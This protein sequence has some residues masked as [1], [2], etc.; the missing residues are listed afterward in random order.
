M[1]QVQHVGLPHEQMIEDHASRLAND[2]VTNQPKVFQF[3]GPQTSGKSALLRA[4]KT[5]L[6]EL[7]QKP[8]LVDPPEHALDAGLIALL[9]VG[10]ALRR[11]DLI[12]GQLDFLT[13]GEKTWSD[14]LMEVGQWLKRA[15]SESIVLLLDEP[16]AWLSRS[17]DDFHFG[18]CAAD[19][20]KLLTSQDSI[21]LVIA[22]TP[23]GHMSR[24]VEV[25]PV[26]LRGN[27]T[28]WLE[29]RGEWGK[30]VNHACELAESRFDLHKL[31]PL[32]LRI[33]VAIKALGAS[34]GLER[35]LAQNPS[36][37]QIT[38]KLCEILNRE[39]RLEGIR[40]IWAK[41]ALVRGKLDD[42]LLSLLGFDELEVVHQDIVKHCLL[43]P[44]R[45]CLYLHETLRLDAMQQQWLSRSETLDIHKTLAEHY[46]F[47]F[48]KSDAALVLEAEAFHHAMQ[49]GNKDFANEFRVFFVHQLDALGRVLSRDR[50]EYLQAASMYERSISWDPDD[51]YA[52]HYLAY[53]LDIKAVDHTRVEEHYLKALE[54]DNA[55]PWWISRWVSYLIT[56]GRMLDAQ[57]AWD[58]AM[59]SLALPD[60][61]SESWVYEQLHLWVARL[62][63]HRGQLEFT[64]KV[65]NHV[66]A[67][68]REMHPG[69]R[70]IVRRLDALL[71]ARSSG[72]VFPLSIPPN[73]WWDGPHLAARRDD[74]NRAISTWRPGRVDELDESSVYILLA[75]PP[76][77]GKEAIFEMLE[78]TRE[79]FDRF[80]RDK[81]S[82]D[83]KP[84]DFLEIVTYENRV[85]PV[86]RTHFTDDFV[87]QDLPPLFPDPLRYLK[88]DA[89]A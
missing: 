30:L 78:M 14:K 84:G 34:D 64:R 80:S 12:D 51:D 11:F 79:N 8:V 75:K 71:Q 72:S 21:R 32:M 65:L 22:G 57:R 47:L 19:V 52:H 67:A 31:T 61:S 58:D 40:K 54:I 74:N 59:D 63:L 41:I 25:K 45:D 44:E 36:R 4:L 35:L 46:R 6:E 33:M 1:T 17:N 73:A 86:I 69:M 55:N 88:A 49:T 81:N 70:A 16:Q 43:Y 87:D 27:K 2:L 29:K 23:P 76:T 77:A 18:K 56:R 68:V 85:N 5:K 10:V 24:P 3:K 28:S 62:A 83:L 13:K 42:S 15:E 53:N 20:A 50:K 60:E 38:E 82:Q 48:E 37:R 89:W 66:P 39:Q 26:D 9:K 7:N